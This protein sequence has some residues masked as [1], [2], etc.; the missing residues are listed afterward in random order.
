MKRR[1]RLYTRFERFWHW[2]Q[3]VLV[4][5]LLA[6]G[7]EVH[8]SLGCFGWER[9][10]SVHN[11]LAW[12]LIGLVV[13]AAFWHFTTGAWQQYVPVRRRMRT[14][15]RY[16]LS[17]IFRNE[18]HPTKKSELSKLNPLQRLTYS[19]LKV[20]VFPVQ[21]GSGLL[22]YFYNELPAWGL[23]LGLGTIA[24]VHTTASYVLLSFVIIHVYLT[25]TGHTLFSN[26]MAMITGWED[27]E[28]DDEADAAP[29]GPPAVQPEAAGPADAP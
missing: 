24:F 26:I 17:G 16:Y 10:V 21:I 18:P 19:G 6:T 13:F 4:L 22:Y 27:I 3:A 11:K 12:L 28:R 7:F 15:V 8:G 1:V 23:Q 20:I 5:A 9:A 25:T 29:Q 14:M 2:A